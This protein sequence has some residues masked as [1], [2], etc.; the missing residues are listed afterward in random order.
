V[1][2][3]RLRFK[4]TV[5]GRREKLLL[6]EEANALS[7]GPDGQVTAKGEEARALLEAPASR[8]LASVARERLLGDAA[9]RITA[10]ADVIAQFA[11]ERAENLVQDHAR[12]RA[13][14]VN[15]PRVSVEAVL[16]PDIV[17]LFVLVPADG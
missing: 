10:Q 16:P 15:V 11:R 14:G 9:R 7:L 4:L 6:V 5:H 2:L 13:T 17:G 12:V 1:A 3:L 8:D